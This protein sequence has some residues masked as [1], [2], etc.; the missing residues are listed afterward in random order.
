MSQLDF[1]SYLPPN[2]KSFPATANNRQSMHVNDL[3]SSSTPP[4]NLQSP[5]A[6]FSQSAINYTA[7]AGNSSV[8]FQPSY[9]GINKN[10]SD[11]GGSSVHKSSAAKNHF[12]IPTSG[13]ESTLK[14]R[15]LSNSRPQKN[16]IS[17][18]HQDD[19]GYVSIVA[20]VYFVT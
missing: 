7:S 2:S 16:N 18:N 1:R 10:C 3:I 17:S 6:D 12:K 8:E 11:S 19:N 4:Q 5:A 20:R 13:K 15:I 14:H 9:H